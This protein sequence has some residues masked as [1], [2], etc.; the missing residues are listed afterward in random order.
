MVLWRFLDGLLALV[1]VLPLAHVLIL[2]DIPT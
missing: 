2:A 1:H